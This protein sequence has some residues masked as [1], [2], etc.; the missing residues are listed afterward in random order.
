MAEQS[1]SSSDPSG[2]RAGPEPD[3]D[4]GW[5][6]HPIWVVITTLLTFGILLVGFLAWRFPGTIEV[7]VGGS[8]SST[9]APQPSQGSGSPNTPQVDLP[10]A[11]AG[12]WRGTIHS[13]G[14]SEDFPVVLT[15]RSGKVGDQVG[16][17]S[18]PTRS[19]QCNAILTKI[20]AQSIQIT[21]EC[22]VVH[23]AVL[24][25]V[26]DHTMQWDGSQP[27]TSAGHSSAQLT[28]S[29]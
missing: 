1:G 12:E 26:G 13:D 2:K 18:L 9:S 19:E 8:G 16:L 15:I 11:Y 17:V 5:Q 21:P 4:R 25:L 20:T 10:A 14:Y 23:D 6:G 29:A 27:F 22:S 28:K 3:R 24:T 7:T